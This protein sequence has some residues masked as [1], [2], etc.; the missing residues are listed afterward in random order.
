MKMQTFGYFRFHITV[1]LVRIVVEVT[2]E[3]TAVAIEHRNLI[4]S[5]VQFDFKDRGHEVL[6]VYTHVCPLT[7]VDQFNSLKG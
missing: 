6:F 4:H 7:F 1:A 5:V 2:V 3:I